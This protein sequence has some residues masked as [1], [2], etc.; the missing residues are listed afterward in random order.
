MK[1]KAPAFDYDAYYETAVNDIHG[2][3]LAIT[4]G[5]VWQRI[6]IAINPVNGERMVALD[7][8][9]PEGWWI[10]PDGPYLI[11]SAIPYP[12]WRRRVWEGLRS[13]PV[14]AGVAA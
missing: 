6:T 7:A 12:V 4:R 2:Q 10:L 14:F 13:S 8:T 11:T 1:K 9:A 3:C 5:Q